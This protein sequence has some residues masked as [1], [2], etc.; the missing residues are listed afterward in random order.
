MRLFIISLLLSGLLIWGGSACAEVD[1]PI[2]FGVTLGLTG[3]YANMSDMQKKGYLLWE[4][5]VNKRGGILG[6]QVKMI[7]RNDK[8][9]KEEAKK[10]Y[11][12][13]IINN[14]CDLA[15]APYSSG[16]TGAI[17]P[18]TEKYG[19]PLLTAGASADSLWRQGYRYLFGVYKPAGKYAVG[20]LELLAMS[21]I[22]TLAIVYA[23]DSFSTSMAKGAVTW[24][25]RFGRKVVFYEGFK[26]G[27]ANL[28]KIARMAEKTN[29]EA[30]MVCGH[31]D[32]ALNMRLSLDRIGWRPKAYFATVGPVMQ[33][34]HDKLK[35]KADHT[36]SAS[37]W[38]YNDKTYM[39]GS[40][41]F[42]DSFKAAYNQEPVY[43]AATAYAAGK[44]FE[45]AINKAG[46]I[47]REK[48]RDMLSKMDTMTILGRY[49]VDKTGKQI[50]HFVVTLQWQKGK[51]EIVWPEG[52]ITSKPVFDR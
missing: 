14:R 47:D 44:I 2:R 45:A 16:I 39:P 28:D 34:F 25:K 5:E 11:K 40:K 21:D 26:K 10:L 19:Y 18:I 24:A 1:E 4:R 52:L 43:Q 20:F 9:D 31:F 6:R 27:T 23:D 22:E 37:L 49:G 12:D 42:Y 48:V 13:F 41:V 29:A 3:K 15:F 51:K 7:I 38:E 36:F 8:S 50:S 46:A 35:D 17:A 30:L 32:E 33:A